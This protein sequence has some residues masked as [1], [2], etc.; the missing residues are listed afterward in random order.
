MRSKFLILFLSLAIAL[1]AS[2]PPVKCIDVEKSGILTE[3]AVMPFCVEYHMPSSDFD[4]VL[5]YQHMLYFD[6]LEKDEAKVSSL[7]SIEA[8]KKIDPNLRQ[9]LNYICLMEE[10]IGWQHSKENDESDL[11]DS[12]TPLYYAP[13]L[14]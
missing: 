11:S 1:F 14:A 13:P 3:L 6:V 7:L 12:K 2:P 5:S 8:T 10:G 4:V 9:S